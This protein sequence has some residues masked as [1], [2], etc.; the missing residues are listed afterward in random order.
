MSGVNDGDELTVKPI[1][2]EE[3]AVVVLDANPH[4]P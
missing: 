1:G 4:S 3:A 2:S